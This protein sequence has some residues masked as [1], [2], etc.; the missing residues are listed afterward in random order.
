M[1][2]LDSLHSLSYPFLYDLDLLLRQP[3]KLVHQCVDLPVGRIDPALEGG[4]HVE[5][6]VSR[7]P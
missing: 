5:D 7:A 4:L 3:I 2:S 6:L 1:H